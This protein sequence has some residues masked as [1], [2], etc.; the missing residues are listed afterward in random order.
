[1][2]LGW[3]YLIEIAILWVM[4]SATIVVARQENWHL[5]V[6]LPAAVLLALAA[7]GMLWLAI[8]KADE[9][10]EEFR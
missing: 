5:W 8:P 6:A 1:M 4:V 2:S 3:K 9:I 7:Y 10:V